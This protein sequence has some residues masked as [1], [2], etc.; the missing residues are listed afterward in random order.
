MGVYSLVL[1]LYRPENI[2]VVNTEEKEGEDEEKEDEQEDEEPDEEE[3]T[4]SAENLLHGIPLGAL[5][6]KI[7]IEVDEKV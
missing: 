3:D 2:A 1:I 6:N 4:Q 7:G 5:N